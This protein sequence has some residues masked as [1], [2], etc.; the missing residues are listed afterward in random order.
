MVLTIMFRRRGVIPERMCLV[1]DKCACLGRMTYDVT[2][3]LAKFS[4]FVLRTSRS[5]CRPFCPAAMGMLMTMQMLP[6]FTIAILMLV[7]V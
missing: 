3:F 2:H 7:T 1:H 4:F 6:S 5:L